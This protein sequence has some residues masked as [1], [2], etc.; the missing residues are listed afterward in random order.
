M[1]QQ[2][3]QRV[4]RPASRH[5]DTP[6]LELD[7][8]DRRAAGRADPARARRRPAPV[9]RRRARRRRRRRAARREAGRSRRPTSRSSASTS[10][11]HAIHDAVRAIEPSAR[12]E[13]EITD[14]IQ[15]L[16]RPGPPGAPRGPRRAG[17]STPA[18]RTRCSSATASC[19][20][21]SSRA[22]DGARRRRRRASKAASSSR[23]APSSSNSR[24]A[25]PGD[26]RRAARV[27][28]DTLRRAVHVDRP[29][30]ASSSTPRSSTRCVLERSRIVGVAPH[31]TT[32]CS[33]A[34][35]RSCARA[36]VPMATR[37]MLGDHSRADLE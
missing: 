18:R 24:R 7:D 2:D 8:G 4:R 9:R 27:L 10:S 33:A 25:R 35:S 14:A 12:G 17:G 13:L 21:R 20:R 31:R 15:W 30:T 5:R 11:T 19:S 36:S 29:P 37:L 28:V 34:R 22:I 1:L 26:H 32:R 3:L 6:Q 16:H 23:P